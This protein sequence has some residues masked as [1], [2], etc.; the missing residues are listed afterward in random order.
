M[1]VSNQ[2][3]LDFYRSLFPSKTN[4]ILYCYGRKTPDGSINP[5]GLGY[6]IHEVAE[7]EP[8]DS[9]LLIALKSGKLIAVKM[10]NGFLCADF[11]FPTKVSARNWI[12]RNLR[13]LE[14]L[15]TLTIATPHGFHAV[16]YSRKS[17]RE[18]IETLTDLLWQIERQG[19]FP[20]TIQRQYGY[21]VVP[22]SRGYRFLTDCRTVR[23]I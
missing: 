22:P 13:K 20:E 21:T 7:H 19:I 15:K 4:P 6:P 8:K 12:R 5:K 2:P 11:D 14:R 18:Q 9:E 17:R 1:R 3:Y 16:F 10:G 23:K